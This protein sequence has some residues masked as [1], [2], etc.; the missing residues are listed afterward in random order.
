VHGVLGYLIVDA[1][2]AL[3]VAQLIGGVMGYWGVF[4]FLIAT[5][6]ALCLP[7]QRLI[8]I[9][10]IYV[11]GLVLLHELILLVEPM[12]IILSL[13]L[14]IHYANIHWLI[15]ESPF[16]SIQLLMRRVIHWWLLHIVHLLRFMLCPN[17]RLVLGI[18]IL[19]WI[20]CL[21]EI[22]FFLLGFQVAS[23]VLW[24]KFLD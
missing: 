21:H 8:L 5:S 18:H 20:L 7:I 11:L 23:G 9:F 12:R 3:E 10:I 17:N 15:L 22:R 19:L 24:A 2:N 6:Y 1:A 16:L 14:V 4:C 13:I